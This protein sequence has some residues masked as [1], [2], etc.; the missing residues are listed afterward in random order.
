MTKSQIKNLEKRVNKITP[1]ETPT[2]HTVDFPE[3]AKEC[4][5]MLETV[6]EGALKDLSGRD[7]QPI[8]QQVLEKAK[9]QSGFKDLITYLP[10]LPEEEQFALAHFIKYLDD[11]GQLAPPL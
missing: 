3:L 7:W 6:P 5:R 4:L 10:T 1:S 11:S 9:S 2:A 8:I